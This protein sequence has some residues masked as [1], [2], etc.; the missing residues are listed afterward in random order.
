VI[1]EK[2]EPEVSWLSISSLNPN[3]TKLSRIFV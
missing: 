1:L 3:G 2:V